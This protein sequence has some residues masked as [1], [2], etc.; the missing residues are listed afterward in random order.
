MTAVGF[1]LLYE[2]M[3]FYL[4]GD[5]FLAESFIVYPIVY[6]AGLVFYKFYGQKLYTFDFF[7]SAVFVWFILFMREPYI[8][9]ALLLFGVLII[10]RPF[11]KNKKISLGILI[12][13]SLLTI[14]HFSVKDYIFNVITINKMTVLH[15]ETSSIFSNPIN[16]AKITL[17]PI[18]IFFTGPWNFFREILIVLDLIFF[19]TIFLN[20]R[21]FK[22]KVSLC[23]MMVLLAFANIRF[24][25]PGVIFYEGF[26]MIVWFGLF[27][28]TIFLLITSLTKKNYKAALILYGITL[29][30]FGYILVSGKSY[31]ADKIDPQKELLT[32]YGKELQVGEVVRKLS[33]PS[34]T[35]FL[36]GFD[37]LIYWQA[38]RLSPYKYSWYTSFMHSIP[39]YEDAKQEMFKKNPPDFYY[40]SCIK[41]VPYWEMPEKS[42]NQYVRLYTN[43]K[44]SCLYVSKD[45]LP[46]ITEEQ[47]KKAD[48]FGYSLQVDR[49]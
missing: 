43:N 37:D 35:L 8:P 21:Y 7:V 13:L 5:R 24:T 25:D 30:V 36:D 4:F 2:F 32:H 38:D 18:F 49:K 20:Y 44:P 39:V 16:L 9:L 23:M 1:I 12:S 22:S 3:K 33:Y 40:G 17:Y 11:T 6:L 15:S 47:W 29:G 14:T 10:G 28:F 45:K 27:L 42:K 41:N 31:I 26:H 46:K 19:T 48:E 34:D